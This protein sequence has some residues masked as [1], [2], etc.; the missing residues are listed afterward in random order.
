MSGVYGEEGG[1]RASEPQD[2]GGSNYRPGA[3]LSGFV[4]YAS[5][6]TMCMTGHHGNSKCHVGAQPEAMP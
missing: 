3:V 4:H 5:S 6:G 1:V 2:V